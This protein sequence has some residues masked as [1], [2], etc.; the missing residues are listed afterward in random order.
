MEKMIH[1]ATRA[2]GVP[3]GNNERL[4][5][6]GGGG[7]NTPVVKGGLHEIAHSSIEVL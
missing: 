7:E 4:A 5:S 3:P 6:K 1:V 2:D